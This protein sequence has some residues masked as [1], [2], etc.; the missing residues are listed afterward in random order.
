MKLRIKGNSI[1]LR[2]SQTEVKNF[3]VNGTCID[4]ISF[5]S[6]QLIY[7]LEMSENAA[8]SVTF[9]DQHIRVLVPAAVGKS[10]VEDNTQV[11]FDHESVTGEETPLYVLVEKD[12]ACLADRPREDE[13][14]NFPN[15]AAGSAAC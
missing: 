5:G 4:R 9:S 14:D 12:F 15:P 7:S 13:S 2:L 3:G 10:W 11:G 8:I 1:R 6:N